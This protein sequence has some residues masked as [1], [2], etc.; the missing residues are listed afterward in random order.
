MN[1]LSWNYRGLGQARTVRVLCDL[2]KDR[3]PDVLFLIETI[4]AAN[5]IEEL[6]IK[7]VFV[8]CFSVDCIG[9]SGGLAVF[10]KSAVDCS[11]TGYSSHHIDLEFSENNAQKWRLSC[12]YGYPDRARRKQSWELICRLSK[13][14]NL[15]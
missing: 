5:K 10:W 8:R 15:P 13:L 7:L 2:V 3:R 14:S 11:I 9:R 6:R 1:C 12:F 4:S